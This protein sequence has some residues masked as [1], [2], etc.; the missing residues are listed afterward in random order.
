MRLIQPVIL[1]INLF[2][3]LVLSMS[4]LSGMQ[5]QKQDHMLHLFSNT[6]FIKED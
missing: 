5:H 3:A 1:P 6:Y 4:A 2:S